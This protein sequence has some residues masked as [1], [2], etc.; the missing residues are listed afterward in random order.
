MAFGM[1]TINSAGGAVNDLFAAEGHRLKAKGHAFEKENYERAAVMADQNKVYT[2]WTTDVK[3]QQA[4]R[5]MY[6]GL[7]RVQSDVAGAGLKMSGSA[8]DLMSESA[9]NARLTTD[10]LGTQGQITM[11]GYEEEARSYRN[12]AAAAQVA[13]DA[14]NDAA[15]AS[16]FSSFA[17]GAATVASFFL[18]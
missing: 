13:I 10:V 1:G 9:S 5:A 16:G 12:M 7:G 15:D 8:L 14:E 2:Q 6:Q 17:K 3:Q 11:A 18:K 4:D